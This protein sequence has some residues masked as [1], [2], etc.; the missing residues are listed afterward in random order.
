MNAYSAEYKKIEQDLPENLTYLL[1]R[2]PFHDSVVQEVSR[3]SKDRLLIRL[4]DYDVTF[5]GLSAS[6]CTKQLVGDV[7]L[8]KE[9]YK[10]GKDAFELLVLL[11]DSEMRIVA[12]DVCCFS[13]VTNEWLVGTAPSELPQLK[14]R[15]LRRHGRRK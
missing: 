10:Y 2:Y 6:N 11:E 9:V 5:L 13:R 7:W 8:Y 12:R 1:K 14:F 15:T 3:V 4:G